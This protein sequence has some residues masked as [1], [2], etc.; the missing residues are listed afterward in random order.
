M[1]VVFDNAGHFTFSEQSEQFNRSGKLNRPG[2]SRASTRPGAVHLAKC[3][4]ATEPEPH[5]DSKEVPDPLAI[6]A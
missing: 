4:A 1:Q 6:S 5:A 3:R 2:F